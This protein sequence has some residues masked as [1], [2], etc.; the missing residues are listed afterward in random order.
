MFPFL[1]EV[2]FWS[3]NE[4]VVINDTDFGVFKYYEKKEEIELCLSAFKKAYAESRGYNWYLSNKRPAKLRD[5][6]KDLD[7]ILT[8]CKIV[9]VEWLSADLVIFVFST[10]LLVAVS[11]NSSTGDITELVFDKFLKEKLVLD[12][13][14]DVVITNTSIICCYNDAQLTAIHLSKPS[15]KY[16]YKKLIHLEPKIT[17]VDLPGL[18][19]RKFQRKLSKNKTGDIVVVWWKCTQD[20]IFPWSPQVKDVDRANLYFY[21]ISD[22]KLEM[23][24]CYQ[25][26]YDPVCVVFS[27]VESNVL[28]SIEEKISATGEISAENMVY[29][30][31]NNSRLQRTSVSSLPLQSSICCA[32]F[33]PDLS[34]LLIGCSDSRVVLYNRS[35]SLTHHIKAAFVP[36]TAKWHADGNIVIIMSEQ[37]QLQ[38]FDFALNCIKIQLLSEDITPSCVIDLSA[39]F[40]F[41]WSLNTIEWCSKTQTITD[42]IFSV[43]DSFVL[44]SF[45]S[46]PLAIIRILGTKS[47]SSDALVEGYLGSGKIDHAVN[48]LLALNWDTH[49]EECFSALKHIFKYSLSSFSN[50]STEKQAQLQIALGSFYSPI[51]PISCSV[52]VE[53][54]K[55]VRNIARI[56]FHHL[57]RYDVFDKAFEV[58]ADLNEHDLYMD[59]YYGAKAAKKLTLAAAAW[60]KAERICVNNYECSSL[61]SNS[62][63]CSCSDC[64]SSNVSCSDSDSECSGSLQESLNI[65]LSKL[66]TQYYSNANNSGSAMSSTPITAFL[67]AKQKVK[68]SNTVTHITLPAECHEIYENQAIPIKK[69]DGMKNSSFTFSPIHKEKPI[70][71]ERDVQQPLISSSSENKSIKVVHFGVV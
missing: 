31:I 52:Q 38:C 17:T 66:P 40:R 50:F 39:Y 21:T 70:K 36:V 34:N 4:D 47:V 62:C 65:P 51:Q 61:D 43:N 6:L 44:L 57:L 53:Y 58:A 67:S 27:T 5:L 33:S 12:R 7:E 42:T 69:A 37:G 22:Y 63:S 14:T 2:R 49:S 46:G 64:S 25:T 18:Q 55:R 35:R 15:F 9:H 48:I 71:E 26:E 60:R 16:A 1:I 45:T 3:L 30:I 32:Q 54:S 28:Y 68:F 59:I 20:E 13:I 10:G 24:C 56:F 29:E 19:R 11:I 23:L 8:S 41:D